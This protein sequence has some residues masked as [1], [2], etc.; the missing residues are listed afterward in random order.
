MKFFQ[1]ISDDM[2]PKL[3]Y[4]VTV[5]AIL[6]LVLGVLVLALKPG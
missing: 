5:N 6:L 3:Q 1:R 4:L 2:P